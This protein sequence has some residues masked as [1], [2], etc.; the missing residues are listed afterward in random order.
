MQPP[1]PTPNPP[2]STHHEPSK[3]LP[4]RANPPFTHHI[5]STCWGSGQKTST[6][7]EQTEVL[8]Y[9]PLMKSGLGICVF[10]VEFKGQSSVFT[11]LSHGPGV[12]KEIGK[13][14]K[15]P[16]KRSPTFLFFQLL[17]K[18]SLFYLNIHFMSFPNPTSSPLAYA[19]FLRVL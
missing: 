1:P 2:G 4:F 17:F 11:P 14:R 15:C 10:A 8:S 19:L 18:N 7:L 13:Q 16:F 5:T 12:Q 3:N 6:D 9:G